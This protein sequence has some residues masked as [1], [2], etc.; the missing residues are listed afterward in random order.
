VSRPNKDDLKQIAAQNISEVKSQSNS[1][2]L[3]ENQKE[4]LKT[5]I[6]ATN[7]EPELTFNE[8][9]KD[10]R[11]WL[12]TAFI[13]ISLIQGTFVGYVFKNYGLQN[14]PDDAFITTVGTIGAISNGFSRSFWAN[15]I[16]QYSIKKVFGTLLVIQI[17]VGL[18]MESI[19]TEKYLYMALIAISY[20]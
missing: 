13:G 19:K 4:L 10:V 14:I 8:A 3:A 5:Q 7:A 6:K 15:L 20:C 12:V 11:T 2:N 9:I 1:D 16:D 17:T 18:M